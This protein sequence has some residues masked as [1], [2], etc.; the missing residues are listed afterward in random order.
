MTGYLPPWNYYL[1]DPDF[2]DLEDLEEMA[3]SPDDI[4][5]DDDYPPEYMIFPF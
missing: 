3:P 2:T 1:L 4:E 5:A